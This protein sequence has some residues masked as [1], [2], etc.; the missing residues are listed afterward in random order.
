[1]YIKDFFSKKKPVVGFEIFPPKKNVP[2]DNVIRTATSL[3]A[4]A[5]DYMS[6][7]YGAGAHG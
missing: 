5:P 6:V 1:M 3:S 2:L 7:T 4:N